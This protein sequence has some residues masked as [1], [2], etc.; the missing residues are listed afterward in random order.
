MS[1]RPLWLGVLVGAGLFAATHRSPLPPTDPDAAVALALA[2]GL[3]RGDAIVERRLLRDMEFLGFTGSPQAQLREARRLGLHRSDTVIRRRLLDRLAAR[4]APAPTAA[5]VDAAAA[6]SCTALERHRTAAQPDRW[7]TQ[8]DLERQH[9]SPATIIETRTEPADAA[10]REAVAA[11]VQ[12]Q[13][14]S[15]YL[16]ALRAEAL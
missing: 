16:R 14:R 3:D 6:E 11:V 9:T 2:E 7:L 5:Q 8:R 12:A 15:A 13:L 4:H 1:R 10:C